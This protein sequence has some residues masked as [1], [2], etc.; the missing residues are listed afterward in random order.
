MVLVA[1]LAIL[2]FTGQG[3][4]EKVA[5]VR[6]R[7]AIIDDSARVGGPTI[8][9]GKLTVNGMLL[10]ASPNTIK[11]STAYTDTLT[12][13][14]AT[15]N[16]IFIRVGKAAAADSVKYIKGLTANVYYQFTVVASDSTILWMDGGNLKLGGNRL[17][18]KTSDRLFGW[19]D[20]T[21]FY[22]IAH[23]SND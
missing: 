8:I 21:N 3:R 12:I 5:T 10:H 6:G 16:V 7:K 23:V 13:S 2:L 15:S 11:N 9:N 22:E 19:S 17:T 14:S 1:L 18:D 20:G 4:D